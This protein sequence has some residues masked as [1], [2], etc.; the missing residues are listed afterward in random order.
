ML[1]T[2]KILF[3]IAF[4]LII[5][6]YVIY[7][8][9]LALLNA[10]KFS[11]N[12]E[13]P[14][15]NFEQKI[16]VSVIVAVYNEVNIIGKK[17]ESLLNQEHGLASLHIYLGSDCSSDGSNQIME[18]YDSQHDIVHFSPFQ[19]R[20]G[21]PKVVNDLVEIAFK[22]LPPGEEH[23]LLMTDAN[24]ILTTKVLNHLIKH[25]SDKEVALVDCNMVNV[26][27]KNEGIAKSEKTYI[28]SEVRLK[29]HEGKVWGRMI[30]PFGG[31][32]ALRST[33]FS[34]IPPTYLVDDFYIAMRA[35]EQGG[36]A[37]NDMEAIC[38]ETVS[39]EM[40]EEYKRKA[41][42][43][44]GNFQNLN[45]FSHLLWPPYSSLGFAFLSHKV[46][47]WLGPFLL[48]FLLISCFILALSG[49]QFYAGMLLVLIFLMLVVPLM[50]RGL[51]LVGIN[52]WPFRNVTYFFYMNIA[53]LHGF[54][55]YIKGIKN[56]VWE[57]PKRT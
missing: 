21:K 23:I 27:V 50:D 20:R 19:E 45:T 43:S 11:H 2:L 38:Y 24:V 6:T 37:L 36:K 56:N 32:Y 54:F 30:G 33:H 10:L 35:F 55:N 22:R 31:C 47:R 13:A 41:R 8:L 28:S 4:Y 39:T 7:P 57:P 3:W 48:I 34:K 29:N 46:I 5:H 12:K 53:L 14:Q 51:N 16:H 44:A 40:K 52:F 1:W 17:I 9:L 18:A 49:N 42:I 26:E 25:F 15:L